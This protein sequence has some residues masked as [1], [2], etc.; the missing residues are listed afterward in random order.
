MTERTAFLPDH[1]GSILAALR[2][3]DL[4]LLLR[5]VEEERDRRIKADDYDPSYE[6]ISRALPK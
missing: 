1:I 6:R 4:G 2:D 5:R 3:Y